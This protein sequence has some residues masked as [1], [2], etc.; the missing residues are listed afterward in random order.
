MRSPEKEQ[1][2]YTKKLGLS[3][4]VLHV[5]PL[6]LLKNEISGSELYRFKGAARPLLGGL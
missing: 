4:F 5:V 3:D 1:I 6:H 2:G